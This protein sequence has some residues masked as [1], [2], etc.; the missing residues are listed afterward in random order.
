M[1]VIYVVLPLALVIAAG[2]VWAFM[3]SVRKGQF[4]DLETP[5]LRM[6]FDDPPQR[7]VPPRPREPESGPDPASP[8]APSDDAPAP[9]RGT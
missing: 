7:V 1:S 6:L 2:M 8:D 9:P 4:D 3:R 5:A